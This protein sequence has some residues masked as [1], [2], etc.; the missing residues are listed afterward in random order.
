MFQIVILFL[1]TQFTHVTISQTLHGLALHCAP[2]L[3]H[4]L[5]THL[6]PSRV[7]Q[8]PCSPR[9]SLTNQRRVRRVLTN[10]R[11]ELP[12]PLRVQAVPE[13][14]T[15]LVRPRCHANIRKSSEAS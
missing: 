11:P 3:I 1:N 7:G 12:V 8:A 13:H 6:T 5:A 10:K 9:V 15:A 2:S 14:N 4:L